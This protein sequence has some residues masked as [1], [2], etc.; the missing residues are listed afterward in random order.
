[1][2]GTQVLL[3]IVFPIESLR[4]LRTVESPWSNVQRPDM[5]DK[6]SLVR[7]RPGT[8]ASWPI[9]RKRRRGHAKI[10]HR[11]YRVDQF[12]IRV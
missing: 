5:A 8:L 12:D 1:M 3:Q 10:N 6:G 7:K 9:A 11:Q 2:N 4:T